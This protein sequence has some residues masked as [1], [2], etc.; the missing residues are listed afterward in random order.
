MLLYAATIAIVA[1]FFYQ[2]LQ[3]SIPSTVNPVVSLTITYTTALILSLAVLF[4]FPGKIDLIGSFK[5]LNWASFGLGFAVIGV[6]IG[7]LLAYRQGWS[8]S[9]GFTTTT[10]LAI[11]M[12]SLFEVIVLKK[13]ISVQNSVGIFFCALGLVFVNVK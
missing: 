6:E 8:L 13:G 3:S 5:Q 4:L 9:E 12:I 11:I 2:I 7:Y 10:A 1:T